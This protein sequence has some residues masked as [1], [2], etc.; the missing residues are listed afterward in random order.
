MPELSQEI[1]RGRAL[2]PYGAAQVT[3]PSMVP[4]LRH[5]DRLVV[6]WGGRVR[7]GDVV[8]LR[9]PFQQDLLV[10]KRAAERRD[11]GWWVLGDNPFAGGDSTDYGTVPEE[12]VLGRVRLR[13]R[14]L[15]AGQRSPLAL[16]RWAFSAARPVLSDRSASR[17]LRAR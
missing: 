14:P 1:E 6:R 7:A 13:Y 15:Q 9:H 8:V 12:L 16:A 11:G 10:V 5:G 2:L 17:R 4:T 3:G